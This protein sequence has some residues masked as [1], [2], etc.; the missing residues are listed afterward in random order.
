MMRKTMLWTISSQYS[1]GMD[2]WDFVARV[3]S[4]ICRCLRSA[5]PFCSGV[6]GHETQ[7]KGNL[8]KTTHNGLVLGTT[9]ALKMLYFCI[10]KIL[11]N[12]LKFLKNRI[13]WWLRINPAKIN[14]ANHKGFWSVK[15]DKSKESLW[16]SK[17][18]ITIYLI[19][20]SPYNVS[21][22]EKMM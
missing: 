1:C 10:E 12:T 4:I 22:L 17:A 13:N 21:F 3:S 6:Y 14:P 9:I 5:R 2:A 15:V 18:S 11:V 16:D 20:T 7:K 19:L 8:R